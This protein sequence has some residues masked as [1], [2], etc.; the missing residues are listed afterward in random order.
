MGLKAAIASVN[1]LIS[2]FVMKA[3]EK[4]FLDPLFAGQSIQAAKNGGRH[5]LV[6]ASRR[7]AKKARNVKRH[8]RACR[9]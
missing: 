8:R 7:A 1:T 4:Q 2:A 6:A 3:G 9:G 5:G